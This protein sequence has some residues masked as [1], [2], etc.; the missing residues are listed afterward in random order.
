MWNVDLEDLTGNRVDTINTQDDTDTRQVITISPSGKVVAT[1]S[2]QSHNV[3][4]L[5]TNTGAVIAHID[6]EYEDGMKIAFS[7]CLYPP[8]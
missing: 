8:I 6:V 2:Q 4:L 3:T 7:Q 5:D 1:E